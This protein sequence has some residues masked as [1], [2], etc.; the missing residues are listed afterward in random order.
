GD[1]PVDPLDQQHA[2]QCD[3]CRNDIA[4]LRGCME[5]GTGIDEIA[6]E[7]DEAEVLLAELKA[8]RPQRWD[9]VVRS[10][11]RFHRP[12]LARRMIMLA[13]AE[14]GRDTRMALAYT[15]AATSI[16]EA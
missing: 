12:A 5:T 6:A 9:R 13:L 14:R 11:P 2:E 16:V 10:E 7:V 3:V 4:V 1:G 15:Y 8:E